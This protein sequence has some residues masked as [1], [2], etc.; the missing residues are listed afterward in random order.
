MQAPSAGTGALQEPVCDR[1]E[2]CLGL[3]AVVPSSC[4]LQPPLP[5]ERT[6]VPR[7]PAFGGSCRACWWL[8]ALEG[9]LAPQ[10]RTATAAALH[11]P[12]AGFPWAAATSESSW[13]AC[14]EQREGSKSVLETCATRQ[15]TTSPG[16]PVSPCQSSMCL[17][18]LTPLASKPL[19]LHF[20]RVLEPFL[21]ALRCWQDP[22]AGAAEPGEG[23]CVQAVPPLPAAKAPVPGIRVS[24][25]A[26]PSLRKHRLGPEI[27]PPGTTGSVLAGANRLF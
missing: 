26:L 12:A 19:A 3:G 23:E 14:R 11:A 2:G 24:C 27:L 9:L 10:S 25:K 22:S 1:V 20:T 15:T 21:S 13:G 8:L 5:S 7:G 18:Q 17:G 4:Q 6:A 16:C